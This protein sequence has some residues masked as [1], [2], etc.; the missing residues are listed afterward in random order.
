M[1]GLGI[2]LGPMGSRIVADVVETILRQD[3]L[4]YVR[5]INKDWNLPRWKFATVKSGQIDSLTALVHLFGDV[6]PQGCQASLRS[7]LFTSSARLRR[8]LNSILRFLCGRD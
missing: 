7:R 3:P 8:R 1:H 5:A 6:L 2:K 4:S